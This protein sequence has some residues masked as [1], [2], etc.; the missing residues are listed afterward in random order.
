MIP[1]EILYRCR[2][3][4]WVS[5]LGI[6]RA[7]GYAP[8]FV[9]RQYRLRQFILTTQGLAQCEFA[10]KVTMSLC[11]VKKHSANRRTPTSDPV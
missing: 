9:L 11:Q 5:L 1:N 6:W 2:D 3:F 10:Y 7:I 8:L 4:D